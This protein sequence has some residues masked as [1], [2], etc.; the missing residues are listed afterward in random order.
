LEVRSRRRRRRRRRQ[1]PECQEG[2]QR[3]R[4][5]ETVDIEKKP[6]MFSKVRTRITRKP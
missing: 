5:E 6:L 2:T 4:K 1:N 3:R